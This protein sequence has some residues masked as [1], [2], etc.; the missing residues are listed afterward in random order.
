VASVNDEVALVTAS[1]TSV[2]DAKTSVKPEAE[3]RD[4]LTWREWP[5][6]P[7]L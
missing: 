3:T 2:I 7:G 5:V 1:M 6:I 4:L